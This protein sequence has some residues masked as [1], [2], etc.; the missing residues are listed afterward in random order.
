MDVCQLS[1]VELGR[2]L[3]SRA[4][5]AVEALEAVLDRADRVAGPINPFAVRL[6]ER[7]R[8]AAA[9]ADVALAR[10]EAGP[11]CGVP[12]T[13]KDS[14]WIAG[15]TAATGSL[16]REDYV[17]DETSVVV[18][19]LDA[20][21]A[22]IFA[23]TATPEFCYFG[24]TE[25]ALTGRTSNPW[26]L[27][28][29]P[30]GSSGGAG[31]AVAAGVGALS[32][33]G[34]GGGSIR[35]PAAFC[36]VVGFKPTFGLVP[37]EPCSAGWKTLVAYGPMT[38]SVAD[39]RMMLEVL[40]GVDG[41]DRHSL[42]FGGLDAPAPAP[43]N[44]RVIASEDLGFA[45]LDDDVRR[46]F[47]L[48]LDRLA[49][50]GVEIVHDTPGLPSSVG[51]WGPIAAAEARWAEAKE[52][53]HQ[54]GLLTDAVVDFLA[55]GE[56]ITAAQYIGAQMA[57]E[58]IHR[59]Y[60]DLFA[61]TGAGILVTPALG[62]EAFPHG[63]T[64]PDLLGEVVI[65]PTSK[66]WGSLLYDANLAGLPACVVPMGLG[67]DGLPVAL[68]LLGPRGTDGA[69]LAAAETIEAVLE[70]DVTPAATLAAEA[71]P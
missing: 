53:E 13:V 48:A 33:G 56:T 31:A 37:R 2:A 8:A 61:R 51:V 71:S 50:A 69:V 68:Q 6:D 17:P 12:L 15:V 10:G 67:D 30:G 49:A 40:A 24:I 36:G 58:P 52:F 62:C 5:S 38:R 23:K 60:A 43:G 20:A 11:L 28:R 35:I 26:N 59:A 32:V 42:D 29:V 57:R 46:G 55:Y 9:R 47:R 16:T 21:G 39:A 64:H 3:R 27:Y 25:S 14:H 70:F 66:D 19:R 54:R 65:E 4:L 22:V 45:P 1:A 63:K 44:L 34:D 7:A 18:E 41:R